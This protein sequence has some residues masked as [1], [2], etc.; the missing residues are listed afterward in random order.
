MFLGMSSTPKCKIT[1]RDAY[2]STEF[3]EQLAMK[4]FP[5]TEEV[6]GRYSKG[7]RKGQLRGRVCWA[8]VYEG[9]GGWNYEGTFLSEHGALCGANDTRGVYQVA[10]GGVVKPQTLAVWLTDYHGNVLAFK[11]KAMEVIAEKKKTKA[12]Q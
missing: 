1:V 2:I 5:N 9:Q 12:K 11:S 6:V 7:K 8:K 4:Y 10:G 3:G